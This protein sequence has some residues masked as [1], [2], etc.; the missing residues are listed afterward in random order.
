M[1]SE[2]T[3]EM[4]VIG[5]LGAPHGIRGELRLFS[6]SDVPG[7]FEG[8][9]EM[10]WQGAARGAWRRLRVDQL[11]SGGDHYLVR[12]AGFATR[13]QA[14]ALSHGHLALPARER[15]VLPRGSYFIDQVVGLLVETESGQPLG[16]IA[17]VYRT[18]ANDIYAV[19]GPAGELLLP[20]VKSVVLEVDLERG[21]MRVRLPKGLEA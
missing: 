6:V 12:F 4:V 2:P 8:L 14:G 20:A 3:D 13:E 11:R 10:W 16:R 5:R 21:R 7:R 9:R 17:E 1:P 18:G 19:Q 15:P